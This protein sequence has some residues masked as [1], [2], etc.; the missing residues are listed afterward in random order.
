MNSGFQ[1]KAVHVFQ[2]ETDYEGSDKIF[3]LLKQLSR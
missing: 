3:Y 2:D 1:D